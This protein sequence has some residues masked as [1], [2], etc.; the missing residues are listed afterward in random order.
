MAGESIGV[1]TTAFG[2]VAMPICYD[3]YF[4]ELWA[5]LC[6]LSPDI[7]FFP[8]L[9]RSDHEMASEALLKARAMDTNSYVCRSSYGR[10]LSLTFH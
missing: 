8:S 4:P 5:G 9:Q 6:R 2:R 7:L 3:I 1:F 10:C